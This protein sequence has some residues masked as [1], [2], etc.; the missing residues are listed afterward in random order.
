MSITFQPHHVTAQLAAV[1]SYLS[2]R[3]TFTE[4]CNLW[5]FHNQLDIPEV[6]SIIADHMEME[7]PHDYRRFMEDFEDK[8]ELAD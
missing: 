7:Y 3:P 2:T 6:D 5:H 1:K 8:Y 4:L